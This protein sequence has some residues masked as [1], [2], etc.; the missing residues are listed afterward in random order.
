MELKEHAG[1]LYPGLL[2]QLDLKAGGMGQ[3]QDEKGAG[4]EIRTQRQ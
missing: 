4:S 2:P 1:S 3:G